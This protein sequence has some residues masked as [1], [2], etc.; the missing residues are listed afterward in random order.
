MRDGLQ[1]LNITL[2]LLP[3]EWDA[4]GDSCVSPET[5]Y[6]MINIYTIPAYFDPDAHLY[7]QYHS[8]QWGSYTACSFYKNEAVDKLLDEARSTAAPD[9]RQ[10]LYEE[11]NRL[12]AADQPAIWTFTDVQFVAANDCVQNFHSSKPDNVIVIFQDLTMGECE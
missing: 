6:E 8:S 10:A 9:K 4:M 1:Q 2:N 11:A 3:V 7:N 5:G 12:I